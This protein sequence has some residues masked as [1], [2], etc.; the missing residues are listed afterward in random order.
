M[1]TAER[2][3]IRV[4]GV[5]FRPFVYGLA[6]FVSHNSDGVHI[7]VEGACDALTAFRAQLESPPPPLAHIDSISVEELPAYGD[8]RFVI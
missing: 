2:W 8:E 4:Q 6:G 1:S 7:E 5:G 3:C